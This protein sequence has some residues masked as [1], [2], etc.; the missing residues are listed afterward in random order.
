MIGEGWEV[1]F[2]MKIHRMMRWLLIIANLVALPVMAKAQSL[3]A[4]GDSPGTMTSTIPAPQG[5]TYTRP[6]PATKLRNYLFD[7][8]GPYPIVGAALTA[9]IDQVHN[10]PPEWRQG[11]EGYGKRF[12][13]DFSIAAVSTTTRYG[14]AQVFKEDTMY[15]RCDCQGVF[16][17]LRHALV[18]TLTSRR[19]EDG[20]R[21]FS[22]PALVAPYAGTMTA[23]YAWYPHRYGAKDAFRMGNYNLLLFAGSNVALEFLF[24]GPHSLF[25]RMHLTNGHGPPNP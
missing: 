2:D 12:A 23:V 20:H 6:T 9:G 15:Y 17:R 21:I 5:L 10:A 3:S 13:S 7:A 19:G 25:T 1:V 18:S 22:F 16:P 11:A 4:S 14:L 8:F 24:S